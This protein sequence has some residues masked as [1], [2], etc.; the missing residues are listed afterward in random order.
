M[1]KGNRI[2]FGYGTISVA[3][4]QNNLSF[5]EIKPPQEIGSLITPYDKSIIYLNE[6]VI[7]ATIEEFEMLNTTLLKNDFTI[8]KEIEFK[9]YILDFSNYNKKSVDVVLNKIR[10]A[11]GIY[12]LTLAC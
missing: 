11:M 2:V 5:I 12:Q 6:I 8:N 3:G 4:R 10:D 7:T 9:G 1:I